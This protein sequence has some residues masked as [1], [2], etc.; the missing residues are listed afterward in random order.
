MKIDLIFLII[1][2]LFVFYS[3]NQE[4]EKEKETMADVGNIDQIKEAVKQ[5]YMADVEA[6]RNLSNVATQIQANGL[7]VPAHADIKGRMTIGSNVK[8]KD[9]PDW[10]GLSVDNPGDAHIRLRSKN[11]DNKNTYLI[12]RDGHFRVHQQGVGDLFGVNHDGHTYNIHT[13]DHVHNFIGRGDNP[14]I[15]LG[16]E[17]EWD[18]KT[19][20][21]QNLKNDGTNKVFRIGVHAE[22][23]KL[24]IHRNGNAYFTGDI[25]APKN[26]NVGG[27]ITTGGLVLQKRNKAR[28]IRVGNLDATIRKDFWTIIE[29]RA[30]DHAGN[31]VSQGKP[32]TILQG[33]AQPGTNTPPGNITDGRIFNAPTALHDNWNLGY[34]GAAG[35]NLL[36]IDLGSEIDL[37]ELEIFN[38]WNADACWRMDGTTIEF[39][40]ADGNRNRIIYTGLWH[41]QY[42][43]EYLL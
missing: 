16:K 28:Y 24:D 29:F 22:G 15:S 12:N 36:Q 10:L 30:Y 38:R 32:V 43:K 3:F 6:I 35:I 40:G 7:A 34:H 37:A 25:N 4:K 20:Y 11:D 1:I 17:G 39:F 19:W 2:G 14:F 18:N 31:N 42:S 41:R 8:A 13:G 9:L 23:P 27:Q 33:S 26:V 5:V 21:M